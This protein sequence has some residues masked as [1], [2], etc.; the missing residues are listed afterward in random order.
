MSW[1]LASC[2]GP[3]LGPRLLQHSGPLALWGGCLL[4]GLL[5][6]AGFANTPLHRD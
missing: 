6:A 3:L 1:G 5:A 2:L 4:L